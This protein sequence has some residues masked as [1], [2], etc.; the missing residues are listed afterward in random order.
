MIGVSSIMKKRL[1]FILF[2]LYLF[3]LATFNYSFAIDDDIKEKVTNA[4]RGMDDSRIRLN[5][6]IC[7]ISGTTAESQVAKTESITI[8]FDYK[9]G[10]YRFNRTDCY[11]LRTPEYY[12]ELWFPNKGNA[13]VT[14]QNFSARTPSYMAKPFDIQMLGFF[15]FVGPYWNTP[16]QP[17]FRLLLFNEI[18]VSYEQLSEDLILI[19][20]RRK[21]A[22][23]NV[24]LLEQKYWLSSKQGYSLLKAEYSDLVTIEMSWT[25]KNETWV[26]TA[27]KLSSTQPL[28]AAWKYSADWKIDWELV[29]KPIPDK[30]FDPEQLSEKPVPVFSK[31]LGEPIQIGTIG[32][33]VTTTDSPKIKYPYFRY[34]LIITGLILIVIALIKMAYDRW[35]KKH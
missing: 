14:R 5:S 34:V 11:S 22:I 29:N 4:L 32:K 2:I 7:H 3:S 20:T 19:E 30:Y 12:Y 27:F 17:D 18:P 26:P 24:P 31:E 35:T 1:I 6:G 28:S 8:A 21:P 15:S 9:K 33:D 13:G 23:A 25:E 10:M 16:Y